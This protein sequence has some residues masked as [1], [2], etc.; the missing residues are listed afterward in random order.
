MKAS[1]LIKALV[2]FFITATA[3][4]STHQK[5]NELSNSNIENPSPFFKSWGINSTI[6]I[7][8]FDIVVFPNPTPD[9]IQLEIGGFTQIDLRYEILNLLGQVVNHGQ[10]ISPRTLIDLSNQENSTY[11]LNIF[12][13]QNQLIRSIQIVKEY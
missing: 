13:T 4:S 6:P 8:D 11:I 10:I 5:T 7:L 9:F 2:V 12:D 3:H 1:A